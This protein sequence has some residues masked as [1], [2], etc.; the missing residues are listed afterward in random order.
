MFGPVAITQ[1]L[2]LFLKR[3]LRR[4]SPNYKAFRPSQDTP[5]GNAGTVWF[6]GVDRRRKPLHWGR[7]L[8]RGDQGRAVRFQSLLIALTGYSTVIGSVAQDVDRFRI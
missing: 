1:Q 2:A 6:V 5:R 8:R 3:S 7:D 4:V